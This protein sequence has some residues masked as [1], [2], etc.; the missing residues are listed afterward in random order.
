LAKARP[1]GCPT[2]AFPSEDRTGPLLRSTGTI[3]SHYPIVLMF[4]WQICNIHIQPICGRS[5]LDNTMTHHRPTVWHY[6]DDFLSIFKKRKILQTTTNA[7][8]LM[9][10]TTFRGKSLV[11]FISAQE[12]DLTMYRPSNFLGLELDSEAMEAK[13]P[14]TAT[15]TSRQHPTKSSEVV[16]RH[17]HASYWKPRESTCPYKF[18]EQKNVCWERRVEFLQFMHSK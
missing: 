18:A 1:K 8:I 10:R 3:N 4:G 2:A 5:T 16:S 11:L 14:V 17:S 6:L 15:L 12:N 13:A 7:A 9:D